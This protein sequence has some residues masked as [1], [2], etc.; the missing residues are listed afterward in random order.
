MP[1]WKE[2]CIEFVFDDLSDVVENSS[3]LEGEGN[4]VDGLLLHVSIHV[5]ELDDCP[6]GPD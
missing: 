6:L 4:A 3:L 1:G 2:H 5:C